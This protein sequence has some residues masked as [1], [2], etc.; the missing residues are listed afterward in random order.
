MIDLNTLSGDTV[1]TLGSELAIAKKTNDLSQVVG[2]VSYG[3]TY[4]HRVYLSSE[5]EGGRVLSPLADIGGVL[6]IP[7]SFLHK[8]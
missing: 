4:H 1:G 3:Y 2:T 5:T 7:Q 6:A 8:T